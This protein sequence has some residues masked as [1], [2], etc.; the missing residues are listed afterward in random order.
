VVVRWCSVRAVTDPDEDLPSAVW[1]TC[2]RP[3]HLLAAGP[4]L[5]E[6]GRAFLGL[7]ILAADPDQARL[8]KEQDPAVR[9]GIFRV[10]CLPWLIPAGSVTFARTRFPGPWPKPP[11]T[12]AHRR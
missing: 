10:E 6:P 5:R 9:A 8:L 7:S 3:G 2:T 4:L 11:A 1:Q 12:D